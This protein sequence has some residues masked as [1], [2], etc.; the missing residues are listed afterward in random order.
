MRP[1]DICEVLRKILKTATLDASRY[2]SLPSVKLYIMGLPVN[3]LVSKAGF[4][5]TTETVKDI[6]VYDPI[7]AA[8]HLNTQ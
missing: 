6:P 3:D 2:I 1:L 5:L 7:V 8:V 4:Y